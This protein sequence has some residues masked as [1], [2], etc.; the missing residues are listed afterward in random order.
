MLAF[1]DDKVLG[2]RG[3]A[4]QPGRATGAR[5]EQFPLPA[6]VLLNSHESSLP[7]VGIRALRQET[8]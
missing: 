1:R 6:E 4:D 3:R 5:A 2:P 8:G 7:W